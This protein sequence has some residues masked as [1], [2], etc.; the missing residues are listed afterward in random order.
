[1]A[2][3]AHA[4]DRIAASYDST[5]GA[6]P[7][8]R[9]FRYVFQERLLRAF[10]RGA[11]LLDLGCGTGEDALLL[12]SR[13]RHVVGID[14][15][16]AMVEAARARALA[17][18]ERGECVRFEVGQLEDLAGLGG[19]FDGAYSDFGALNCA[20]LEAAGRALSRTLRS[21]APVVVSVMG[22]RPL[23]LLLE[24]LLTGR[25]EQRGARDPSVG[26]VPIQTHYPT[27]GRVR[28]AF[29]PEFAWSGGLALGVLLPGPEHAGWAARH[30]QAFG[31]LATFES[32]V[33]SWPLLRALGDHNVLEGR[34][35]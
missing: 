5:F 34:R 25:G 11:R 8:G 24:R 30:P 33:R 14:V 2:S 22:P 23:P 13:R 10:P 7:I 27:P 26:G 17:Q 1:M 29:G 28:R 31:L 35:R 18:G 19:G 15:S 3:A 4:F 12:A 16:P 32:L 9:V 21:G 20:D 6:N